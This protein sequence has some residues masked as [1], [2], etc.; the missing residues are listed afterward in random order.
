MHVSMRVWHID[1][2]IEARLNINEKKA[3]VGE[4]ED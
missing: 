1:A 2:H 4:F 3:K